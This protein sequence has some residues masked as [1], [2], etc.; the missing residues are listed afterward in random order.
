VRKHGAIYAHRAKKIRVHQALRL[1][2]CDS[3]LQPREVVAGV[4]DGYV[5][6]TGFGHSGIHSPLDRGLV[7]YI[8]F[9]DVDWQRILFSQHTDFGGILGVA[10]S[11]VTHR[12]ENRVPIA[13]Q[14]I[15]EQSPETGAGAGDEN[16][17]LGIHDHPSLRPYRE[18]V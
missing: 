1:F 3:F 10:A 14:S 2:G 17:L 8:Q 5:D 9:K 7:G 15:S 12:R 11:G 4:V 6:A 16:H 13:S 18:P